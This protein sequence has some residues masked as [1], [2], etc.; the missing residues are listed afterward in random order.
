M[1]CYVLRLS[2]GCLHDD[3]RLLKHY[4]DNH[5][6]SLV[7]LFVWLLTCLFKATCSFSVLHSHGLWVPVTWFVCLTVCW[8][9][10]KKNNF[11][12]TQ[13]FIAVRVMW[14]VCLFACLFK[15]SSLLMFDSHSLWVSVAWFVCVCVCLLVCLKQFLK[16][17]LTFVAFGLM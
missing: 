5:I 14:T 17:Q 13:T 16:L 1:K 6:C 10:R 3:I 11:N 8:F 15:R 9:V 12:A 2:R 4:P 7:Y